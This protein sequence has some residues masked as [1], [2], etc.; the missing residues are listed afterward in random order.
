MPLDRPVK[1]ELD[2]RVLLDLRE[3]LQR[4]GAVRKH[5]ASLRRTPLGREIA[6]DPAGAWRALTRKLVGGDEWER[7][8]AETGLLFFLAQTEPISDNAAPVFIRNCAIEMGWQITRDGISGPPPLRD[9]SWTFID[10]RHVW[11]AWALTVTSGDW[12]NR[13]ISLTDAGQAAALGYLRHV[14]AGPNDTPW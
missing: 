12:G 7:F 4:I 3:W 5:K 1:N 9:V 11:D 13:R 14:A 6:T 8:V 2:D 10:A